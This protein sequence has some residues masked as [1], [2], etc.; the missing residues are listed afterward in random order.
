MLNLLAD[1]LAAPPVHSGTTADEFAYRLRQQEVMANYGRFALQTCDVDALLQEATQ[2]CAVGLQAKLAKVMV[3]LP[4]ER[5]FLLRAGVGWKPGFVGQARAGADAESPAGYAFQTGAPVI[6]NHLT[7]ESRFRTPAILAE[8]GVRR[9]INVIIQ[10][11]REPFG[12]LEVDSPDDGRFTEA[13]IAFMEGMANML[14]LAIER[15]QTEDALR[16]SEVRLRDKEV[17]LS[18]SLA[19][20]EVLTAEIS[21]RVKNSLTIVGS[22]LH[23]QARMSD[24][25]DVSRALNDAQSRVQTIAQ[26]HDR[27]WRANEIHTVDLAAFLGE[28][29]DQLHEVA[30]ARCSVVCAIDPV[31]VGTDQAVPLGLLANELVTNAFKYAYPGTSG[32][33]RVAIETIATNHFRFVVSD[34]GVGLPLGYDQNTSKSLGMKL[35]NSLGRQ[36]GGKLEW[37]DAQPGTRFILEFFPQIPA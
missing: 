23:L 2:L 7:S 9:A 4:D 31:T 24:N 19:H 35:I 11:N 26:V 3:Y 30:P 1:H 21:H 15:Q 20:Q 14:G 29:V 36:L 25:A 33:V 22:L 17:Q 6:S 27:L 28:L 16:E 8:H 10:G 34:N 32:E 13:D 18:Q 37:Q 12:V 5:Q